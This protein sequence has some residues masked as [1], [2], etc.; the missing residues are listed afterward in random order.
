MDARDACGP[1]S[2]GV[3]S[4]GLGKVVPVAVTVLS[5]S[6]N[7]GSGAPKGRR[8]AALCRDPSSSPAA[9]S[10]WGT[11][12]ERCGKSRP[13][14]RTRA[15]DPWGIRGVGGAR[16]VARKGVRRGQRMTQPHHPRAPAAGARRCGSRAG[17]LHNMHA[18]V[19]AGLTARFF[20]Y[21]L[22]RGPSPESDSRPVAP[23]DRHALDGRCPNGHRL[24]AGA[25][26][27]A[28]A[29]PETSRRPSGIMGN[30]RPR[31]HPTAP[32]VG[33]TEGTRRLRSGSGPGSGTRCATVRRRAA[34]RSCNS[35]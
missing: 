33:G 23:V 28:A 31:L 12:P 19:T 24:R 4:Q 22:A 13:P 32:V 27:P 16:P 15:V 3:E 14:H 34:A 10:P 6:E 7:R 1:G 30:R 2:A 21:A 35:G 18:T 26:S 9:L 29:E 11:S 17:V 25:R 5:A 8:V 20:R